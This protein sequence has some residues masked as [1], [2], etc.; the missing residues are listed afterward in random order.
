VIVSQ[1]NKGVINMNNKEFLDKQIRFYDPATSRYYVYYSALPDDHA[2][3][4]AD[5]PAKTDRAKTIVG[6]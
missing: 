1:V 3:C 5:T 4:Q 2:L 6:V